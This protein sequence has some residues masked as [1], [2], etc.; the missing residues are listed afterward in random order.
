MTTQLLPALKP[1]KYR[2]PQPFR[3]EL[4]PEPAFRV[5]LPTL[6]AQETWAL[7][8]LVARWST[9]QNTPMLMERFTH[10]PRRYGI[11][12]PFPLPNWSRRQLEA[13]MVAQAPRM[14]NRLEAILESRIHQGFIMHLMR[15]AMTSIQ[16]G[17][18]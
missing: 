4:S 3:Q 11:F 13:G 18:Y 16:R 1:S 14:G 12:P 15:A 2:L 10:L 9:E 5:F 17:K 8:K 6:L 7:I